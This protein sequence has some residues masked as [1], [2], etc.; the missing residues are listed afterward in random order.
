MTSFSKANW[1]RRFHDAGG[2][3]FF[4]QLENIRREG[5]V[6]VQLAP[7]KSLNFSRDIL[8]PGYAAGLARAF[9]DADIRV[10]MLGSYFNISE[11]GPEREAVVQRYLDHLLLAAWAGFPVIGT[12]TGH[13]RADDPDYDKAFAAVEENLGVVLEQAEKLGVCVAVEPVYGHTIYNADKMEMLLERYPTENLRVIY[14]PVNLLDPAKEETREEMWQDFLERL[15][16]RLAVVHVKDYDI[17][18]GRKKDLPAAHGRM[19]YSHIRAL[20]E[21]K[22]GLDFLIE[23]APDEAIPK[24]KEYFG[25]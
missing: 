19:D 17:A 2:A 21:A 15:G 16:E 13:I 8:T 4:A 7:S 3:D 18:D 23:T 11:Y 6:S 20:A 14:D 5:F 25:I 12:E 1:G 9:K 24:I 10:A 22:P